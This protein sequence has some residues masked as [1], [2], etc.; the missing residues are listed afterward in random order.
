MKAHITV[1][2]DQGRIYTGE[3]DLVV[4][5]A[6]VRGVGPQKR[7]T[8]GVRG[9]KSAAIDFALGIRPFLKRYA[10][11]SR[12]GSQKFVILLAH[13]ANGDLNTEVHLEDLQREWAR[14]QGLLHIAFHHGFATRAKDENWA[15]SPR[16]G[17]YKLL[18]DWKGAF[19][20]P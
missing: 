19:G 5:P 16:K 6:T 12:S 1:T 4:G 14:A 17:I 7:A 3:V 10:G 2:D 15:G 9:E 13:L 11:T 18:S 20:S 8:T